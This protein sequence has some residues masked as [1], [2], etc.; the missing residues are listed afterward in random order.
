MKNFIFLLISIFLLLNVPANSKDWERHGAHYECE[1]VYGGKPFNTFLIQTDEDEYVMGGGS[2]NYTTRER[3]IKDESGILLLINAGEVDG[4]PSLRAI[5]VDKIL[6]NFSM[7][8][9][10]PASFRERYPHGI[11]GDS[12]GKC[13]I[14][15]I[16]PPIGYEKWK[17]ENR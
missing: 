12:V 2:N 8:V 4:A 9:L 6:M 10:V 13:K 11:W 16:G 3:V 17:R 15:M 7:T 5:F 1:Y 14:H